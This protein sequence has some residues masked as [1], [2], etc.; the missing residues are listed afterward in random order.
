MMT[1]TM[2]INAIETPVMAEVGNEGV[3]EGASVAFVCCDE[4][5]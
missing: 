1:S 2:K 4:K 3:M 5:V